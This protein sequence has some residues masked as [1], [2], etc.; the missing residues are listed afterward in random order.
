M[1]YDQVRSL[2]ACHAIRSKPG[3]TIFWSPRGAE[4]W[5]Y[6]GALHR[7]DGPAKTSYLGHELGL[8][9]QYWVYGRRFTED[10][11]N[12]YIDQITGDVMVPP[13]KKL[14]YDGEQSSY[15]MVMDLPVLSFKEAI[16]TKSK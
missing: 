8:Q 9:Q 6:R 15:R 13:G 11:F 16:R 3:T 2:K 10:E 5:R 14:T 4:E 7:T 1:D 12:L